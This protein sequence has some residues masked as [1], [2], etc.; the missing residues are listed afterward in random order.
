MGALIEAV[1]LEFPPEIR[2]DVQFGLA[3]DEG[4]AEIAE[5]TFGEVL[6]LDGA[7]ERAGAQDRLAQ[8]GQD[9]GVAGDE[10]L[11]VALGH[12]EVDPE[13]HLGQALEMAEPRDEIG[14]QAVAPLG[15]HGVGEGLDALHR[16]EG[17][18]AAQRALERARHQG[19]RVVAR[20]IAAGDGD[21]ELVD[22]GLDQPAAV[23]RLAE[24]HAV[25]LN[26]DMR[27]AAGSRPPGEFGQ[28][29]PQGDLGP[30]QDQ[31]GPAPLTGV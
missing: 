27:E 30:G 26:A 21:E 8:I 25:G 12:R 1:A 17:L 13:L 2:V 4:I 16:V 9:V 5:Q 3:V 28:V 14:Q 20:R 7:S 19:Q 31:A 23:A 18:Q 29:A 24:M 11:L 15:H 10:A 22:A 6:H